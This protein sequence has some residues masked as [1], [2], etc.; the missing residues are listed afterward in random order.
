MDLDVVLSEAERDAWPLADERVDEGA[1]DVEVGDR[2]AEFVVLG[3]LQLDGAF[4]DDWP[5]VAAGL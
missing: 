3:G 4:A 5:L 2:V 1:G